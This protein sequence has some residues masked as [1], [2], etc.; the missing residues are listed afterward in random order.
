MML[1]P[2]GVHRTLCRGL[3]ERPYGKI[4]QLGQMDLSLV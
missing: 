2:E 3:V 1:I 4:A